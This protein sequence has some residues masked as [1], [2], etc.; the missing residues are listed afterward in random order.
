MTDEELM[1]LGDVDISS[2]NTY[3][4]NKEFQEISDEIKSWRK[5][6]DTYTKSMEEHEYAKDKYN[7]LTQKIQAENS[8]KRKWFSLDPV[9]NMADKPLP[10]R[11]GYD[12]S[13]KGK[14][15][16]AEKLIDKLVPD[17]KVRIFIYGG[18]SLLCLIVAIV[19]MIIKYGG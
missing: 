1:N 9:S 14:A 2:E 8:K 5:Q 17:P 7:E 13:A 6:R 10:E 19:A 3:E 11:L 15:T 12:K 18:F 4:E 16:N